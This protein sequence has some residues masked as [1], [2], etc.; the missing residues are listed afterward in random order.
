KKPVK[1]EQ[2]SQT[3]ALLKANLSPDLVARGGG[4]ITIVDDMALLAETGPL[5]TIAD[6]GETPQNGQIFKYVVREEDSLLSISKMFDGV[7]VNTIRW[8]NNLTTSTV[9]RPGQILIIFPID[10]IQHTVAK[11]ET[12]EGI[13]KRYGGDI[14]ETLAFNGWPPGYKPEVGTIVVVPNGEGEPLSSS[15]DRVVRGS[16]GLFEDYYG[17]YYL[18]PVIG[19]YISQGFHGYNNSGIDLA[20]ALGTPI[21]ATDN[22]YVIVRRCGGWNGGYGCYVVIQHSNKKTQALYAHMS[23]SIVDVG[24]YLVRGQVLGYAGSTGRSTGS[25]LHFELRK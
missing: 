15:G 3:V 17:V 14:N 2:N 10:S 20:V 5:G 22:G 8:A 23:Q 6:V 4:D 1:Q 16:G 18:R 25:H 12:F 19:G 9:I 11:N 13:V 7:S 24:Q 21:L